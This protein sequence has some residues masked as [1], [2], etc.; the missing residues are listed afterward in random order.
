MRLLVICLAFLAAVARPAA[1]QS[2]VDNVVAQVSSFFETYEEAPYT[3]VKSTNTYEERS[4]PARKWVC[5]ENTGSQTEDVTENQFWKLF[6]YITGNMLRAQ[7][8]AMTVPVANQYTPAS[9][10]NQATY[11]MCFFIGEEHQA[12][13]AQP[14]DET[15]FIEDRP[16]M[17][18]FTRTVGG[19]ME[20]ADNARWFAEA[21]TVRGYL[22]AMGESY[23][24]DT[25]WW[26]GY[27]APWKFWNRRNEV[28]Y[29][30]N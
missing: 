20:G 16:A 19:Y 8:I 6:R 13:P 17:T 14:S 18:I 3:L 10:G 30:K 26:V 12:N 5:T 25:M 22:D 15:V 29:K 23:A 24:T 1:S 21:A 11:R 9:S 4:Y 7:T 2:I 28:W 27:D